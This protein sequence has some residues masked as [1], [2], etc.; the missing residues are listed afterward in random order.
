VSRSVLSW[1][2]GAKSN[3]VVIFVG[4]QPI[5]RVILQL[6]K[7]S[8][9]PAAPQPTG[10]P[11]GVSAPSTNSDNMLH[12]Q[13]MAVRFVVAE[14]WPA[15]VSNCVRVHFENLY[16]RLLRHRMESSLAMLSVSPLSF[17]VAV[18]RV[19]SSM[20]MPYNWRTLLIDTQ[21]NR[22]QSILDHFHL[23]SVSSAWVLVARG[24]IL[25]YDAA[26]SW[27]TLDKQ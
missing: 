3:V 10:T 15:R 26:T 11:D 8:F 13:I 17:F 25:K 14:R 16:S 21:A 22:C 6:Q 19:P 2:R 5:F 4:R 24:T 12:N 27:I 9:S 7:E 18:L 20:S 1:L 23:C